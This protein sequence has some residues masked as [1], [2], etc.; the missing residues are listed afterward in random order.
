MKI[1]R[2]RNEN[3]SSG[4]K[5]PAI[6]IVETIP[7]AMAIIATEQAQEVNKEGEKNYYK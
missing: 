6:I 4:S 3:D 1:L 7:I 2:S 5:L